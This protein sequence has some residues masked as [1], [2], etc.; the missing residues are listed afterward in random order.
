MK[1]YIPFP[2]QKMNKKDH[3][4]ILNFHETMIGLRSIG[5]C[6]GTKII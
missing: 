6:L 2:L 4:P 3:F 1:F 5:D